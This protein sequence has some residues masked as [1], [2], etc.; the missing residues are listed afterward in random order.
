MKVLS[1]REFEDLAR[2]QN[3][4][5]LKMIGGFID[6][7]THEV[8]LPKGAKTR[9]KTHE[10]GHERLDHF[11]KSVS[12]YGAGKKDVLKMMESSTRHVDD[13]IEAEIE[14]YRMMGKKKTHRVGF[15]A[16]RVL[17]EEGWTLYRALSLV[18]GRL[19]HYGIKVSYQDRMDLVSIIESAREEEFE[20]WKGWEGKWY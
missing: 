20:D 11:Q 19:R 15:M 17:L 2:D 12:F 8:V 4:T 13:E 10:V 3:L 9:V 14:S 16:L 18:I 5:N 6:K 7:Y 1:R